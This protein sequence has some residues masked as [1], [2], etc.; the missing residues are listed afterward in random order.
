MG[1]YNPYETPDE[2]RQLFEADIRE[3][4]DTSLKMPTD[5]TPVQEELVKLV[6]QE[7]W[8]DSPFPGLR[9]MAGEKRPA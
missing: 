8:Q 6:T 7:I 1:G 5:E 4:L 2:F 9:A 3:L